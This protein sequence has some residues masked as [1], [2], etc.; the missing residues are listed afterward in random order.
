MVAVAGHVSAIEANQPLDANGPSLLIIVLHY[1]GLDDTLECVAS[2]GQQTYR[3][4]HTVVVD[5]GSVEPLNPRL[6]AAYPWVEILEMAENCGWSGGNN[7]GIRLAIA[8]N[9]DWVC[10]LNNDTVLP[11]NTVARLMDTAAL[12]GPGVL[13]PAI[14]SYGDDLGIQ[15][16]PTIPEPP[17]MTSTAVPGRAGLYEVSAVNGS[18]LL[19]HVDVFRKIGL[20]DERFFLLCEDADLAACRS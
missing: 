17:V 16:D 9:Y 3:N 8:R 15:F 12:L 20:I 6:A 13:H 1:S 4:V 18:C 2:L 5:N 11:V 7:E 10:L 14:D 19:T